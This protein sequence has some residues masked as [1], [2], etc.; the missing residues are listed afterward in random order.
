M[1]N[2]GK[3]ASGTNT[4]NM[5]LK[6]RAHCGRGRWK[7]LSAAKSP[8]KGRVQEE[9]L[10]PPSLLRRTS[11]HFF[12]DLKSSHK[13]NPS[14]LFPPRKKQIQVKRSSHAG[15]LLH[16]LPVSILLSG[17]LSL[18][19]SSFSSLYIHLYGSLSFS[20][21]LELHPSKSLPAPEAWLSESIIQ[22]E[23]RKITR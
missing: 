13:L 16:I 1:T 20:L 5:E 12:P 6:M 10:Q 21:S 22:A 17:F 9:F 11:K 4:M 7:V 19:S 2:I 23:F 14:A 8:N 3:Q 15:L 18:F